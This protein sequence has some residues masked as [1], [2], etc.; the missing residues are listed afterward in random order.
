MRTGTKAT[1]RSQDAPGMGCRR[2]PS[3]GPPGADSPAHGRD[4]CGLLLG[5]GGRP[6]ARATGS[7][8]GLQGQ[9]PTGR[10]GTEAGT[11]QTQGGDRSPRC[12]ARDQVRPKQRTPDAWQQASKP[13]CSC[14]LLTH[15]NDRQVLPE[16]RAS[17][18][19]SSRPDVRTKSILDRLSFKGRPRSLQ[20]TS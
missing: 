6:E 9:E 3:Q 15:A 17:R 11:S 14:H 12:P 4:W 20:L 13:A 16:A 8:G 10:G 5:Q 7:G 18:T 2:P 19:L 1:V